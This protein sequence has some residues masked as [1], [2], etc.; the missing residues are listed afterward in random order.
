MNVKPVHTTV[1]MMSLNAGFAKEILMKMSMQDLY[2]DIIN[3]VLT[4]MTVTNTR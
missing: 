4:I 3:A 1:M 2:K